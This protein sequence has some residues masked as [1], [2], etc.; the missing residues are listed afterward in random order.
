MNI[1]TQAEHQC[2][3]KLMVPQKGKRKVQI[4]STNLTLESSC[5]YK[6]GL[7]YKSTRSGLRSQEEITWSFYYNISTMKTSLLLKKVQEQLYTKVKYVRVSSICAWITDHAQKII[8]YR[9]NTELKQDTWTN[10]WG[11]WRRIHATQVNIKCWSSYFCL[12]LS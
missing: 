6:S 1:S 9:I 4:K 8:L 7:E 12:K 11:K 3:L 2:G 5:R 10:M